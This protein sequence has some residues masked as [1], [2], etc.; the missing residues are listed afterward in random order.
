MADSFSVPFSNPPPDARGVG[1][2]RKGIKQR[3]GQSNRALRAG[4][5][6]GMGKILKII[7]GGALLL[8]SQ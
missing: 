5:W 1:F 8:R 7:M 6:R 3:R 4:P 2:R